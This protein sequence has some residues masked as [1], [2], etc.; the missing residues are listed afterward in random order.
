MPTPFLRRKL[1]IFPHN[2]ILSVG[3]IRLLIL[4]NEILDAHLLLT[5]VRLN[6][7]QLLPELMP[8]VPVISHQRSVIQLRS[9]NPI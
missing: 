3:Y 1:I 4:I 5:V 9:Q 6:C 2:Y 8:S 7:I